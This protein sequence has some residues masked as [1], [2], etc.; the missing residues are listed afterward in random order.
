MHVEGA[1]I[2]AT[3]ALLPGLCPSCHQVLPGGNPGLCARCW[4]R[5]VPLSGPACPR[6]GIPVEDPSEPCLGCAP[7]PPPQSAT[8]FWGEYDGTL[9][10]AILA[11]KHRGRDDFAA[12]LGVR[13]AATVAAATWSESVDTVCFVPS[14]P[15]RR[16]KRPWPAAEQLARVVAR[17]LRWPSCNAASSSSDR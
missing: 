3:E 8:L 7:T 9:R 2:A 11:L 12:A 13:L 14:H 15:L 10:T 6:C 5:V 1:L 16:F 4:S 17:A